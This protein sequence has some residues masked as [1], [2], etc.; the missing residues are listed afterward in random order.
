MDAEAATQQNQKVARHTKQPPCHNCSQACIRLYDLHNYSR[1]A[2]KRAMLSSKCA[3]CNAV[4]VATR[5]GTRITDSANDRTAEIMGKFAVA[6]ATGLE[7]DAMDEHEIHIRPHLSDLGILYIETWEKITGRP[8]HARLNW[9]VKSDDK[10]AP[11]AIPRDQRLHGDDKFRLIRAWL[12][13]SL[14]KTGLHSPNQQPLLPTR[15]LDVSCDSPKIHVSK[16]GERGRYAT[17]SYRWGKSD[18]FQTTW[19]NFD[20]HCK[21]IDLDSLPKTLKDAVRVAKM[22]QIQYLWIDALCIIQRE[23]DAADW[24]I[25]APRMGDI[26]RNSLFTITAHCAKDHKEGFL[27]QALDSPDLKR[28]R[29]PVKISATSETQRVK[30]LVRLPGNFQKLVDDGPMSRRGWIFQERILSNRLL[31]FTD[32]EIF[33]EDSFGIQGEYGSLYN[34]SAELSNPPEDLYRPKS[35]LSTFTVKDW[36]H[37]VE[38]YSCCNLTRE[39]DRLPAI[40]GI[41]SLLSRSIPSPY[42]CGLWRKDLAYQLLWRPYEFSR[43]DSALDTPSWSWAGYGGPVEYS[44][45]PF[46]D[47]QPAI[48]LLEAKTQNNTGNSPSDRIFSGP[49]RLTLR[50]TLTNMPSSNWGNSNHDC[51]RIPARHYCVN[52]LTESRFNKDKQINARIILDNSDD[53]GG[54]AYPDRLVAALVGYSKSLECR[55]FFLILAPTNKAKSEYR[56]VGVADMDRESW[57]EDGVTAEIQLV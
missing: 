1:L 19:D 42:Y 51:G 7:K 8:V 13:Q 15:I 9:V 6:F 20:K 37:I 46:D 25:E 17:L 30:S 24:N 41:A 50:A 4:S 26:Y 34:A 39:T 53:R 11:L 40:A 44:H 47:L 52:I 29:L 16:P 28:V 43:H 14:T 31:H 36:C 23:E 55:S 32:S 35:D 54:D 3:F 5:E 48:T 56:R 49:C 18:L 21:G 33:W 27:R 10:E 45:I 2:A 22:L 12:D 57:F 38:N